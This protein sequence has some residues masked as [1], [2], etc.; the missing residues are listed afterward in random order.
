MEIEWEMW[1]QEQNKLPAK[2]QVVIE[3]IPIKKEQSSDEIIT[4][5]LPF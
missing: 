3:N 5:V 4:N 1:E 2:I